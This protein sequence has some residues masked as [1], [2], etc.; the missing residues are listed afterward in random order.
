MN[1]FHQFFN[2]SLTGRGPLAVV[3][4][5]DLRAVAENVRYILETI[6]MPP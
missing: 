3:L 2:P 1:P 6:R 5:D 4:A